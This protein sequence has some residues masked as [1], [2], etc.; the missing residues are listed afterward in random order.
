VAG[1]VLARITHQVIGGT[2][3]LT[4][5]GAAFPIAALD[6]IA[7]ELFRKVRGSNGNKVIAT[8]DTAIYI[9]LFVVTPAGNLTHLLLGLLPIVALLV[10]LQTIQSLTHPAVPSR[11]T[12]ELVRWLHESGKIRRAVSL[13]RKRE[14]NPG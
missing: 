3:E 7:D 11:A 4:A 2:L 10:L 8:S 14:R 12:G 1:F 9:T 5:L 6:F 13:A